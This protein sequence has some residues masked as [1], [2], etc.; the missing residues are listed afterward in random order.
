MR[1]L[2]FAGVAVFGLAN[3]SP[4]YALS[5]CLAGLAAGGAAGHYTHHTIMGAIGGCMTAKILVADWKKYKSTHADASI[6]QFLD[7]KKQEMEGLL[8]AER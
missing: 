4:S 8:H 5:P 6:S 2:F 1:K 7:E 3:A